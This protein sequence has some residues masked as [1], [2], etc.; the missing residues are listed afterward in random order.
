[1]KNLAGDPD[2]DTYIREEL[3]A[4]AIEVVVGEKVRGEVPATLTGQ[5]GKFNFRRAW[6]YW[7]VEGPM[8]LSVAEEMYALPVGREDVR[9]AGHCGCPPPNQWAFP[10]DREAVQQELAGMGIESISY[11]DLAKL[12]DE[13]KI[14]APRF[15]TSY[16]IDSQAGLALFA[17]MVRKHN[18]M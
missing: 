14:S 3:T 12:C 13:G 18:L 17:A 9:V 1:M 5:L 7:V 15:V 4:A 10:L 6:Y 11:G 16:H 2:C 8:P